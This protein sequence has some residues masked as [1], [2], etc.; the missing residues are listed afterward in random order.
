VS[1][2]HIA[3]NDAGYASYSITEKLWQAAGITRQFLPVTAKIAGSFLPFMGLF[4]EE[5]IP[6]RLNFT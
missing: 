6:V 5:L 1:L 2:P 3:C 4:I